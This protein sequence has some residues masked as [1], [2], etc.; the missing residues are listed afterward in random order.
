MKLTKKVI[1]KKYNCELIRDFGF[2]DS[3]LYWVAH[4]NESSDK[5]FKFADGLTLKELVENIEK[6][7]KKQ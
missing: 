3:H 2:D 1:E 5:G 7:L 6:K 4:E